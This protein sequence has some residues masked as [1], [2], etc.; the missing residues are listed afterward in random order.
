MNTAQDIVGYLI[1]S[2]GGGAQDGEHKAVRHAVIHGVRE[3]IQCRDWKWYYRN[4]TFLTKKVT[5][6]GFYSQGS[7]RIRVENAAEFVPGRVLDIA[8]G[9]FT[10][11]AVVVAVEGNVVTV[12][13][14]AKSDGSNVQIT[15]AVYYDLPHDVSSIDTLVT[16][17]VG[18][19]HH[20]ITPEE[21]QRLEVNTRGAGEPYYYTIMRS[22]KN[23]DRWQIRFVGSPQNR[24]SIHYTYRINPNPIKY[25][26]YERLCRVGTVGLS[27]VDGIMTVTGT[28]TT[29]PQDCSGSYIRFGSPGMPADPHGSTTPF[30][31]ERRVE[32]WLSTTSLQ[33]SDT[34]VFDRKGADGV[35]EPAIDFD[36]G[37]L[38]YTPPSGTVDGNDP[39]PYATTLWSQN[40][41]PLPEGTNYAIT[42]IIDASPQMWSAMLSACEMWYARTAGKPMNEAMAAFNRDL[43]IAM[44]TDYFTPVSGQANNYGMATPRSMGWYS[45]PLPDIE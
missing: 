32:K 24:T 4:N 35:A 17:T 40:S 42:D 41:T 10:E 18:T 23:P 5:T 13:S 38:D 39:N 31:F 3:V 28:K 1:A 20:R 2:T 45:P 6:Q 33:V 19:L 15:P 36:A 16:D 11:H 30:V 43:R 7:D 12:N 21:W 22:D 26:G 8:S 14:K 34:T 27:N 37:E 29:F 9:A 44:E 25:M